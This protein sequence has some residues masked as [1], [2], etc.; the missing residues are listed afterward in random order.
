V[1]RKWS[2]AICAAILGT[3]T[4]GAFSTLQRIGPESAVREWVRAVMNNDVASA[5]SI[6]LDPPGDPY[7]NVLYQLTYALGPRADE[8]KLEFIEV[9]GDFAR[10][11][12]EHPGTTPQQPQYQTWIAKKMGQNWKI[13]ASQ[14][15]IYR[16]NGFR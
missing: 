5:R 3:V 11:V 6:L 7:P 16:Q 13:S 9:R 12:T 14:T 1:N 15:V 10:I 8:M 4:V 2:G